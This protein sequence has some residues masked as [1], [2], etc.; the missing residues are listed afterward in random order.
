MMVGGDR[1]IGR[2]TRVVKFG[3][4]A[5]I[6]FETTDGGEVTIAWWQLEDNV[7]VRP[8]ADELLILTAE[9][10]RL[11]EVMKANREAC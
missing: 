2:S 9:A 6:C 10:S 7:L 1:P 3:D 5:A 11:V 8:T 4:I